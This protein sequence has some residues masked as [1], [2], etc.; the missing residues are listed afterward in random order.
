MGSW[1]A[2]RFDRL[3]RRIR[4]KCP[5]RL[6]VRIRVI[7]LPEDLKGEC[8]TYTD[9]N[10]E[11]HHFVILLGHHPDWDVVSDA[12]LH[13]WAHALDIAENGIP[14]DDHRASWGK[15]YSIVHK[16]AVGDD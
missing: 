15:W 1:D 4:R 11:V 2:K 5:C 16:A 3:K 10:G 7:E 14:Q 8:N 13:E 6:P 12:L 9:E